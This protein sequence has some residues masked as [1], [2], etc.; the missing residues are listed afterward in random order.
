MKPYRIIIIVFFLFVFVLS[1]AQG[2]ISRPQKEIFEKQESKSQTKRRNTHSSTNKPS[3]TPITNIRHKQQPTSSN[4]NRTGFINGHEWVDLGLASGIKWA[5]CNVGSSSSTQY[6]TYFV[7]GET[8]GY[9]QNNYTPKDKYKLISEGVINYTGTL[10]K[11]YDAA[12]ANWGSSWRMPT[13]S[14]IDELISKCRWEWTSIGGKM[15]YK[16][17]GPN[18]SFIFLPAAGY[19]NGS[20]F[21]EIG[22]HC[23]YWSASVNST[24]LAYY[25]GLP[26][27]WGSRGYKRPV[28]PVTK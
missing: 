12:N 8:V 13:K 24:G 18:G 27:N 7:F 21:V 14:E 20:S 15:G 3:L 11:N 16:I 23:S 5:T 2:V 9:S 22:S 6:G 26:N 28:R 4:K 19:N 10:N 1:Y 17:I 25:F